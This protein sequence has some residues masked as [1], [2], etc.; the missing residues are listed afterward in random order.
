MALDKANLKSGIKSLLE[1]LES[2]C[3]SGKTKEQVKEKYATELSNL[4][5]TFVKT[6]LVS[7]GI[8]VQVDTNTGTG[9]TT[10]VGTIS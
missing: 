10:G 8:S 4:I 7:S 3:I 1:V 2:D 9:T 5:E 6:G